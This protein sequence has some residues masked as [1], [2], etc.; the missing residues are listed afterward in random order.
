MKR[1][2]ILG[3]CLP[4]VVGGLVTWGSGCVAAFASVQVRRARQA[5]EAAGQIENAGIYQL[6]MARAFLDKAREEVS[7]AHYQE[8]SDLAK[9]SLRWAR[10]SQTASSSAGEL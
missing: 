6:T 4:L 7:E 1:R 9:A 3:L 8:A 2:G 10:E 5:V